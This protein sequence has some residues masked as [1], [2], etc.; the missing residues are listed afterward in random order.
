MESELHKTHNGHIIWGMQDNAV[1]VDS[2]EAG[3]HLE[4]VL[5]FRW[6]IDQA[7]SYI[8]LVIS[9]DGS[10]IRWK[11]MLHIEWEEAIYVASHVVFLEMRT[12]G[13]ELVGTSGILCICSNYDRWGLG[14]NK[15]SS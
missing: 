8:S 7:N 6:A 11:S 15:I 13:L 1:V 4:C 9:G 14:E 5:L 3:T 10:G 12:L 2:P